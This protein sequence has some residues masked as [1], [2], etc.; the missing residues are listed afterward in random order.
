MSDCALFPASLSRNRVWSVWADKESQLSLLGGA[1]IRIRPRVQPLVTVIC[2]R[3]GVIMCGLI[4]AIHHTTNR[5]PSQN[6]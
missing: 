1:F 2:C 6:A 5:T 3:V 4:T